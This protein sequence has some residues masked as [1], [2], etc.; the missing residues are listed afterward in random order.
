MNLTVISFMFQPKDFI[1]LD[2]FMRSKSPLYISKSLAK[3]KVRLLKYPL[4]NNPSLD[5]THLGAFVHWTA[6]SSNKSFDVVENIKHKY[7]REK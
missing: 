5:T 3:Y 7:T 6:F 1:L 4:W 2:Y